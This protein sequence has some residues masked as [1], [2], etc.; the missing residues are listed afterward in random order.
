DWV[1]HYHERYLNARENPGDLTIEYVDATARV[2]LDPEHLQRVLD[3][4]VDNAMRHS[5]LATGKRTAELRVRVDRKKRE[6]VIDVYD[7]GTGVS[8]A[9]VP[10]LFEPFFTRSSGGSGLGLYLCRELCELNQARIS[11]LP[12]T[13]GR[14]RFQITIEYQE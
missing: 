8:T 6:C 4:L 13:E 11:Y 14:S 3:N 10:R 2:L 7:D 1:T 9:D 12:T 5:E